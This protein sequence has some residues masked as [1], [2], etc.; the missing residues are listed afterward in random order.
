MASE[1]IHHQD[2]MN[3][4]ANE[5][6]D[7]LP[8]FPTKKSALEAGKP[9]GWRTAVKLVRRFETVWLVGKK[10]FQDSYTAGIQ[11]EMFRLPLLRWET[12]NRVQFCPVLEVKRYH[13]A[14]SV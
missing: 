4:T 3:F 2:R 1:V 9:Y 11:H 6:A 7:C 14:K 8:I 13:A 10:D 12:R 5:L